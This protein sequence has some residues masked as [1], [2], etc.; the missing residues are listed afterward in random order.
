MAEGPA[1]KRLQALFELKLPAF[2]DKLV[3][4]RKRPNLHGIASACKELRS[5]V[6]C[7]AIGSMQLGYCHHSY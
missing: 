2:L 1:T 6:S 7:L 5:L 4:D 3:E